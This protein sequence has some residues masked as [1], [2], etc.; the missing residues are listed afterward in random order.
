M[1]EFGRNDPCF[2][3]SGKKYKKCCYLKNYKPHTSELAPKI[4]KHFGDKVKIKDSAEFGLEKLSKAL[5]EIMGDYFHE[6]DTPNERIKLTQI[7]VV[8]WNCSVKPEDNLTKV[9]SNLFEGDN[10]IA[11]V[12]LARDLIERKKKLFPH[13]VNR[14]ITHCGI[15]TDNKGALYLDVMALYLED[16]TDK[17][18]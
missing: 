14:I 17:V 12:K 9:L 11:T 2:C 5:F 18:Q 3:G 15:E 8:A 13:D 6:C 4:K 10:L 16:K 1:S 7:A